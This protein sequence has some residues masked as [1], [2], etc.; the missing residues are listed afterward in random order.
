VSGIVT[1]DAACGSIDV[2]VKC[3]GRR[4][5]EAAGVQ[6]RYVSE[7]ALRQVLSPDNTATKKGVIELNAA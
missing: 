5:M 4:E 1:G 3:L 2:R 7:A 6:R